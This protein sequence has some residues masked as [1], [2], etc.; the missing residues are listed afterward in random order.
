MKFISLIITVIVI[1]LIAKQQ[2]TSNKDPK[3]TTSNDE[4]SIPKVPTAPE[5]V[6][7]FEKDMNAFML[8]ANKQ[9]NEE[10]NNQLGR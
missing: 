2:L 3:V 8:N 9:R 4:V 6:K 7:K 10:L 5:D 1:G